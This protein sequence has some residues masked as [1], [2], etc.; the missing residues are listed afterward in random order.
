MANNIGSAFTKSSGPIKYYTNGISDSVTGMKIISNPDT[1]KIV[2]STTYQIGNNVNTYSDGENVTY[3]QNVTGNWCYVYFNFPENKNIKGNIG[4]N[5]DQ[6]YL[7]TNKITSDNGSLN[8]GIYNIDLNPPSIK[9]TTNTKGYR[10]I[11]TYYTPNITYRPDEGLNGTDSKTST[12]IEEIR[13][14]GFQAFYND[15]DPYGVFSIKLT[16][17]GNTYSGIPKFVTLKKNGI[18]IKDGTYVSSKYEINS[19]YAYNPYKNDASISDRY[20]YEVSE[21]KLSTYK[22]ELVFTYDSK[23]NQLAVSGDN[24]TVY[25]KAK[26]NDTY[27]GFTTATA[28]DNG[29]TTY[30][31]TASLIWEFKTYNCSSNV[32]NK[33]NTETLTQKGKKIGISYT[34]S[35]ENNTDTTSSWASISPTN[36]NDP[37]K[38]N[39]V[40][41]QVK[42]QGA[43]PGGVIGTLKL[44]CETSM[45]PGESNTG[46]ISGISWTS[47]T[48]KK[49]RS[50]TLVNKLKVTNCLS[51]NIW[52]SNG[53]D[54]DGM[55]IK[56]LIVTQLG[57]NYQSPAF[58]INNISI[59]PS[60]SNPNQNIYPKVLIGDEILDSINK[61]TNVRIDYNSDVPV[62]II[63]PTISGEGT[64][65]SKTTG[66]ID[67]YNTKNPISSIL[68]L[69]SDGTIDGT[70]YPLIKLSPTL[71]F[72]KGY[73][74]G[75]SEYNWTLKTSNVSL[76]SI[77]ST[78]ISGLNKFTSDYNIKVN[79]TDSS[80]YFSG[81]ATLKVSLPDNRYSIKR[82]PTSILGMQSSTFSWQ[83]NNSSASENISGS[84]VSTSILS[85]DRSFYLIGPNNKYE[86]GDW[87]ASFNSQ[88]NNITISSST[89]N[90][91]SISTYIQFEATNK[92]GD[93]GRLQVATNHSSG[94]QLTDSTAQLRVTQTGGICEGKINFTSTGAVNLNYTQV[95]Y[96]ANTSGNATYICQNLFKLASQKLPKVTG[97]GNVTPQF[98]LNGSA[99]DNI[100]PEGGEIDINITGEPICETSSDCDQPWTISATST[101]S[102]SSISGNHPI[103]GNP[104]ASGIVNGGD[105]NYAKYYNFDDTGDELWKDNYSTVYISENTKTL[106]TN[107]AP[108]LTYNDSK[109]DVS[110]GVF[111]YY[112]GLKVYTGT[113]SIKHSLIA[114]IYCR[115]S[116]KDFYSEPTYLTQAGEGGSS[117]IISTSY[118][119]AT[120]GANC[121]P[122]AIKQI[123]NS[124]TEIDNYGA[125]EI[126]NIHS[127]ISN[128]SRNQG[129]LSNLS[130]YIYNYSSNI[131]TDNIDIIGDYSSSLS[132]PGDLMLNANESTICEFRIDSS[133]DPT[134]VKKTYTTGSKSWNYIY[135][136][137][138]TVKHPS[139]NTTMG[140]Y[141]TQKVGNGKYI[142][143]R[144]EISKTY[145]KMYRI[146]TPNGNGKWT[147]FTESSKAFNTLEDT[148]GTYRLNIRWATSIDIDDS[149]TDIYGKKTSEF[150]INRKTQD[151]KYE[152]YVES[153]TLDVDPNYGSKTLTAF[154]TGDKTS[155]TWTAKVIPNYSIK[156]VT[157]ISVD[158]GVTWSTTISDANNET[159]VYTVSVIYEGSYKGNGTSVTETMNRGKDGNDANESTLQFYMTVSINNG[160]PVYKGSNELQE[161]TN[162]SKSARANI[163]WKW[164]GKT[165]YN[166]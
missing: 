12:A 35:L 9:G 1:T 158:G 46:N 77:N 130:T 112:P 113:S 66:K 126:K 118:T 144:N 160:Y 13:Q 139:T 108:Y 85:N 157:R 114:N 153:A 149:S 18:A 154:D 74:K 146:D 70:N 134:V 79:K 44:N 8:S 97:I 20:Y 106:T 86:L 15:P 55:P 19:S 16:N 72:V 69:H 100:G 49:A 68:G 71:T 34:W 136:Y 75:S 87:D 131:K 117:T 65:Q 88:N 145:Y 27:Q 41:L 48:N 129:S 43:Q 76:S 163:I 166:A 103:S 107:I 109:N 159:N 2:V 95:D 22:K 122:G 36:L 56:K 124:I 38:N 21:N 140:P 101:V 57:S 165:Y 29:F 141:I 17:N 102:Q 60:T 78:N 156:K 148:T 161:I 80:T 91:N 98:T 133:G 24:L 59:I 111:N 99:I 90:K 53:N 143:D 116:R 119:F 61:N 125:F 82:S 138:I 73:A 151:I 7:N 115:N 81:L 54:T 127:P 33:S 123:L 132:T 83:G 30:D 51:Q 47:Q 62:K 37:T 32:A 4:D 110:L 6:F 25:A 63:A 121:T 89:K 31:R 42:N 10:R 39:S 52:S 150:T 104:I 67:V 120:E 93:T 128:P 142:P 14:D 23:Y 64:V 84:G 11:Y 28:T 135:A 40:K 58:N 50:V 5:A 137:K 155:D 105:V 94:T 92:E 26:L 162:A 3:T 147:I 45:N 96:P 164:Y 152:Y